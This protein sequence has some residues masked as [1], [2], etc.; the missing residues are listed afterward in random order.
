M[1]NILRTYANNIKRKQK[2][3]AAFSY[4]IEKNEEIKENLKNRF[5]RNKLGAL[6]G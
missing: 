3:Y 4:N 1:V 2:V 6:K 5:W